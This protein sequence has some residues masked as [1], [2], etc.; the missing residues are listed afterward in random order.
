VDL[1]QIVIKLEIKCA[2]YQRPTL[3]SGKIIWASTP[4]EKFLGANP[5]G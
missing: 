2:L 5:A 3:L 4:N 1:T